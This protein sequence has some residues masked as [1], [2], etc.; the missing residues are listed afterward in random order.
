MNGGI[1]KVVTLLGIISLT[2]IIMVIPL[3]TGIGFACRWDPGILVVLVTF[4]VADCLI[5]GIVIADKCE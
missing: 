5:I 1:R 2:V 3:L 4:V